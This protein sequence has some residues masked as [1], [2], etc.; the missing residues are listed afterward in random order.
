MENSIGSERVGKEASELDTD[1]WITKR[2][3][4]DG[5]E[6]SRLSNIGKTDLEIDGIRI[7]PGGIQIVDP[8]IQ[9]HF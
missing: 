6:Q 1:R 5:L 4:R 7:C 9:C 3:L 2:A 8:Y